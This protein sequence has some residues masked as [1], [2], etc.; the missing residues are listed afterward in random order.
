MI[1]KRQPLCL[2]YRYLSLSIKAKST[3]LMSKTRGT[4]TMCTRAWQ[5]RSLNPWCTIRISSSKVRQLATLL[6][7]SSC[8]R[9]SPIYVSTTISNHSTL[10]A[11][12][13][14]TTNSRQWQWI[15][16]LDSH[17]RTPSRV[18]STALH[19][20]PTRMHLSN[21]QSQWAIH[22]VSCLSRTIAL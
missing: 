15:K 16:I 20:W 4:P 2:S 8:H 13:F 9:H 10:L 7:L 11:T 5:P 12:L 14:Q 21:L 18:F 19:I 17:P 6:T 1:S 22:R 3:Y